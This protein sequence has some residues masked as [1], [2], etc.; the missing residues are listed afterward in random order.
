LE[1]PPRVW[2]LADDRPGNFNQALAVAEALGWPFT[3]KPIRYGPLAR[4]PNALL[5]DSLRGLSATPR[6]ALAAPWPEL[7]IGAGRRTAPVARW[8]KRQQPALFHVQ[9]MWPGSARGLDLVAVPAHDG[10]AGRQGVLATAGPPHRI[11]PERLAAAA[12]A[13]APRLAGLPRPYVACL[14]GGSSRRMRFTPDD[15]LALARQVDALAGGRGGSL[16][17]TTSRR[18]GAAC[19]AA[20]AGALAAPRLLHRFSGAADNPY[21]GLL[22]AAD[23]VIVTADSA[24]MCVEACAS[25]KPV[26]LFRPAAGVSA[27]LARL[28]R[29][30]EQAGHLRALGA[31]WPERCPPPPNPAASVAL[32]IRERLMGP[33]GARP[34]RAVV[35]QPPTA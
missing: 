19:S 15:A 21:L 7:T 11:T 3:V 35:S 17:V 8:L 24:S 27:K 32:A 2:L 1:R 31:P 33:I 6:A 34:G 23:A 20:L 29:W 12:A 25:G 10:R 4:L 26:F 5:G 18:T 13:L 9:L 28:H 16:L 30:L 22:G 14:V